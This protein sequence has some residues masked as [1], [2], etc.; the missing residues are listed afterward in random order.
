MIVARFVSPR[1]LD[2]ALVE[3]AMVWFGQAR[4]GEQHIIQPDFGLAA[5]DSI[6]FTRKPELR[7]P[8][9]PYPE[10]GRWIATLSSSGTT[11]DPVVSPW[12]EADERVGDATMRAIHVLCP[13][14]EGARCAVI[15]PSPA[16]A[17]A[18]FMRREIAVNGGIALMITAADPEAVCRALV[19]EC[20][21]V[22]FTLPLVAAR[23]GEYLHAS[24][25][26]PPPG[27]RVVFCGGDVLSPARQA[28]LAAMWDAP[29]FNMFGCSELFGPVAGPGGDGQSLVW[30]CE[31]VAV[32]VLDPVTLASCGPGERGVIVLSTLWPKANPL[33]RYWTDDLVQLGEDG[34]MTAPFA[35]DYIGRPPSMLSV[36]GR[37]VP[38]RDVDDALLSSGECTSEWSVHRLADRFLIEVETSHRN[39]DVLR[40]LLRDIVDASLEVVPREPG[41]LPRTTPKFVVRTQAGAP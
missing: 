13:S 20:I 36:A 21:D 16:L 22:V 24:C 18:Y 15:A 26:G 31:P 32:E 5:W 30:R 34:S 41:S 4:S 25:G 33:L 17:A 38:L 2:D 11:A 7:V 9:R 35:F 6:P 3:K 23:I 10:T 14:I 1:L 27:I 28:L 12:S 29:V 39:G 19:A 8:L 40:E 37:E